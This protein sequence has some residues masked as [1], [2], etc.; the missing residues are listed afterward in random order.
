MASAKRLL[1]S[2][3]NDVQIESIF[4]EQTFSTLEV[5]TFSA[6]FSASDMALDFVSS[7][8]KLDLLDFFV[9]ISNEDQKTGN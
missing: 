8:C 7:E 3:K 5:L 4:F 2:A 9:G 1:Q 6:F